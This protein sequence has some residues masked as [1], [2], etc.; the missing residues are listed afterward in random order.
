MKS[1]IKALKIKFILCAV[2]SLGSPVL[3]FSKTMPVT[4]LNQLIEFKNNISNVK[5]I[6]DTQKKKESL[7]LLGNRL[8]KLLEAT[9]KR[10]DKASIKTNEFTSL[11]ILL[12]LELVYIHELPELS[13]LLEDFILDYIKNNPNALNEA[14]KPLST[15]QK[16]EILESLEN[17]KNAKKTG[18]G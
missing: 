10:A 14:L 13:S 6:S 16:N 15:S 7:Y 4:P 5:N 9:E 11:A 12:T 3:L 1:M 17:H 2:F 18:G 8:Y